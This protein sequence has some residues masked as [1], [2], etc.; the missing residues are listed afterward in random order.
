MEDLASTIPIKNTEPVKKA[1]Q[2]SID[3]LEKYPLLKEQK[4]FIEFLKDGLAKSSNA[5]TAE[6]FTGFYR[7]LGKAGQ[8]GNPKQKEH[9]LGIVQKGIKETFN[10]SGKEAEKFGKY[11]EKTNGAWKQWINTKDLMTTIEKAQT[12]E[13]INFKKLSSILNNSENHELAK[14]V[15]GP[16]ALK[17]I[18]YINKGA[19][20]IESML[21]KIPSSNK[22]IQSLKLLGALG[23]LLSGSYKPLAALI[24]LETTKKLATNILIDPKKQN[25]M[26]K[27]VDAAKNN[28]PQQ[29]AILAQELIN[30]ED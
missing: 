22:D 15:L 28:S 1:I 12:S 10:Q 17:N 5:N 26:K 27:I 21:Q 23:S 30:N 9:I 19:Q 11:F 2:Q 13:G 29:A 8:W 20:A 14:K 16:E 4:E 3:Y 7:N 24:S 25:I 18:E 6:F